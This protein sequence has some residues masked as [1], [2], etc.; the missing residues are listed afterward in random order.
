[1]SLA[2]AK[3]GTTSALSSVARLII[4]G[5]LVIF[6]AALAN[7]LCCNRKFYHKSIA[8]GIIERINQDWQPKLGQSLTVCFPILCCSFPAKSKMI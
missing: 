6:L 3:L 2:L 7:H 5:T 1:M 8:M 4:A